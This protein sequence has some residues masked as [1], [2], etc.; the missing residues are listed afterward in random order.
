MP[1][2]H[3]RRSCGLLAGHSGSGK[4]CLAVAADRA[5]L[6]L[7][8]DDTVHVQQR[9]RLR[10]WGWPSAAHLFPADGGGEAWPTRQRNG[11]TKQVVRLRS[12]SAEAVCCDRA[13]MCVLDRGN[14]VALSRIGAAEVF[15]RLWPLEPGFDLVP[16]EI[17]SAIS[18]LAARGAWKLTL[19]DDP[20]EAIRLILAHLP[21]LDATAAP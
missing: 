18:T 4:S 5:D 19:S 13:V 14:A 21:L 6:Q 17:A 20:D 11:K 15:E 12:A 9:P 3:P 10:V 1:G 2:V 16:G 8:S 7:L